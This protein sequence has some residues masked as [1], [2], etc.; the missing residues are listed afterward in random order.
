M[1]YLYYRLSLRF[2]AMEKIYAIKESRKIMMKCEETR[3]LKKDL[4]PS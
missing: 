3:T 1:S 4:R 2:F